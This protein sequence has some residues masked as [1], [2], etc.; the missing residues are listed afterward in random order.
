MERKRF[1]KAAFFVAIVPAIL[2]AACKEK[3]GQTTTVKKQTYTCSMHP[4]VMQEHPGTC[5]IC[6]MDLIPVNKS[7]EPN[8][9]IMLSDEQVQLGNIQTDTLGHSIT[10]DKIVLTATL[11]FDEMKVNTVSARITGRID[12]LYYK[13]TGDYVKK[14]D[15]LFDL[16]SEELNTVKQEHTRNF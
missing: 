14:G 3:K 6:H 1:L 12:K 2:L 13:N 11:N 7:S 15:R 10:G 8:D 16:Y 4:Q 9:E 5:P